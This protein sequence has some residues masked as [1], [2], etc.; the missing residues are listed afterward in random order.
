MAVGNNWKNTMNKIFTLLFL[1]FISSVLNAQEMKPLELVKKV[2]TNKNYAKKTSKYSTGE[3]KGHP[4]ANDL[5]EKTSLKFKLLNQIDNYAVVN[6]T[7]TDNLGNGID[8]NA[9]LEKNKKWK[10]SAF[11]AL[12][13]TGILE[14]I[15][16]E[17]EKMSE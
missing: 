17:F 2:F 9:H 11:R 7:I 15:K 3:Y 4:N 14:Q 16:S 8:T 5:G 12:A 6:I 10:I 13:M 1:I